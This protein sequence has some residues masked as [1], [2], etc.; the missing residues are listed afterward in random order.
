MYF[1]FFVP[2]CATLRLD[3][4]FSGASVLFYEHFFFKS[5]CSICPYICTGSPD[6]Y[7]GVHLRLHLCPLTTIC[8]LIL[9]HVYSYYYMCP[10]TT[11]CVLLRVPAKRDADTCTAIY[12][13]SYYYMCVLILLDKCPHTTTYVSSYYCICV[14][15]FLV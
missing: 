4:H 13:S 9:L 6:N 8:V 12:V 10:H 5:M 7:I 14:R 3:L 15:I 1:V 2:V 11:V